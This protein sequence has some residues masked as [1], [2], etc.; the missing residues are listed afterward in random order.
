MSTKQNRNRKRK[1]RHVGIAK[2]NWV[3]VSVLVGAILICLFCMGI[4]LKFIDER[5]SVEKKNQTESVESIEKTE[6]EVSKIER[7]QTETDTTEMEKETEAVEQE[8][9]NFSTE[10]NTADEL[11]VSFFDVGQGDATLIQNGNTAVLI[12]TGSGESKT[13]M[14]KV[15]KEKGVEKLEYLI[16][17]HGHEDHVG[18][19]CDIIREFPVEHVICDFGNQEG[20]VQRLEECLKAMNIDVIQPKGGESF[21]CGSFQ[22]DILYGRN[23]DIMQG[24]E[25][26]SRVNNQSIALKVVHG[27]NSF[28]FYGDG[29]EEYEQWMMKNK[30]DVKADVLKAP[31]H[32]GATSSAENILDKCNP[33][34]IVISSAP[35]GEFGFPS[36]EVL[37]RYAMRQITTFSTNQLG[38]VEAVSDGKH[39]VW[40]Y[41]HKR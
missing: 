27:E 3:R 35:R 11:C 40:S 24:G 28:L 20:Y 17:S 13:E 31:H 6:E 37:N 25:E 39:I 36:G 5:Y 34:F 21:V 7:P 15:L 29:E 30:I 26:I 16:F 14:V 9:K 22:I 32:G 10:E 33:S 2:R 23:E 38:T 41:E 18:Q 19:G 1:K 12:D 4:L 8:Q